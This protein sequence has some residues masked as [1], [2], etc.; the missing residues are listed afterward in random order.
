MQLRKLCLKLFKEKS[1]LSV[2]PMNLSRTPQQSGDELKKEKHLPLE[3]NPKQNL[4]KM[5]L[6]K[7]SQEVG[8]EITDDDSIRKKFSRDASVF[9]MKPEL[10]AFPKNVEE[11]KELVKFVTKEKKNNPTISIAVRAAG[12]CM[13]GGSLTQSILIQTDRLNKILRIGDDYAIVEPGVYYRDFAKEID[14]RN[15]K[16]PPFPSSWKLCTIGGIVAN[17]TGGEMTLQYGKTEDFVESLKV[18]LSDGE[19]Y[20]IN[21][22]TKEDLEKKMKQDNFEGEF[23]KNLFNLLEKNEKEINNSKPIVS[24][25]SAGYNIWRIWDGKVFDLPKLFTGSQG[26]LGIITQ[27]KLR[28]IKKQDKRRLVLVFLNDFEKVPLLV[29]LISQYKPTSFESFDH[30]TT[31]LAIKYFL[32][33]GKTLKLNYFETFKLFLP[34]LISAA[35]NRV[36]KLTL[37]VQFEA[38]TKEE[39]DDSIRKLSYDLSIVK[40]ISYKIAN[41]LESEKYWAIRHDSFKLL[42]ER[43]KGMYAAPFID[44]TVVPIEVLPQYFMEVYKIL[45]K[46]DLIYTIA[47]HIGNGNFHI[48]PLMDLSL[49]SE[50]RKIWEINEK[51][52]NL[53]WKYHGSNSGEHNDG[54]VRAG[55]LKEQFGEKVY[56]IFEDIKE[57]FDPKEIF[58]PKKKIGVTKEYAEKFMIREIPEMN[59]AYSSQSTPK[60]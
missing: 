27:I 35:R 55:Y 18:I 34:D 22:L 10:V 1:D 5:L 13:S 40:G 39:I 51:I 4:G 11:I 2:L 42:K 23:Y 52:F 49:A 43:V 9:E 37:M 17:N 56:G 47:G 58:N 28:L 41:K 33:F 45:E 57:I 8:C 7:L 46:E 44:D 48:I 26:T 16:Y 59:A 32:E 29:R 24:K 21:K 36:P 20:E 38:D 6:G 60:N 25:N 30:Y 53:T 54:L 14:K 3:V 50:R 12:T 15:L 19:E 31:K